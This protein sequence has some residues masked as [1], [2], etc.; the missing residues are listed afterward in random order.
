MSVLRWVLPVALSFRV[1]RP[2][3][4]GNLVRLVSRNCWQLAAND[5][6]GAPT[7]TDLGANFGIS[8]GGV[9]NLFIATLPNG[10]SVWLRFVDEV[11][12]AVFR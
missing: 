4:R 7:L 3:I 1:R 6:T 8:T 9:L 5:G 10:S 12:S 11:S 2:H